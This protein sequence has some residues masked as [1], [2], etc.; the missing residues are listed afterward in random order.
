VFHR[1]YD[2]YDWTK[3]G[4]ITDGP[5]AERNGVRFDTGLRGNSNSGHLYG[6]E[7]PAADREA[8]IEFMKTL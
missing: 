6:R 2:V 7:L 1:G 4:F 8:L 5:E 3:V